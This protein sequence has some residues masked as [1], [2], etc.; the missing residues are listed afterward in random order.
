MQLDDLKKKKKN[1]SRKTQ[2]GIVDKVFW[3]LWDAQNG[4]FFS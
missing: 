3:I 2:F 1:L 4:M